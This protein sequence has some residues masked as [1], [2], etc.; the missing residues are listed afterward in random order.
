MI[1]LALKVK[2]LNLSRLVRVRLGVKNFKGLVID[3][4]NMMKLE[5]VMRYKIRK[6]PEVEPVHSMLP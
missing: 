6:V 1:V 2:L 5:S 3:M 4:P